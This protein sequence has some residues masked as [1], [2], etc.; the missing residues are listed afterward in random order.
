MTKKDL[1]TRFTEAVETRFKN[2]SGLTA[3]RCAATPCMPIT[4]RQLLE[5][6]S[7]INLRIL[8]YEMRFKT[9]AWM[10]ISHISID[11]AKENATSKS[12]DSLTSK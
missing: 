11:E 8:I 3:A 2:D 5:R 4:N 7:T 1:D 10:Q 9:N 6:P 12:L